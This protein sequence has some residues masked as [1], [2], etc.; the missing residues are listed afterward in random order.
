[1]TER[2][3]ITEPGHVAQILELEANFPCRTCRQDERD[4]CRQHIQRLADWWLT[5]VRER[6]GIETRIIAG[7]T[8]KF[9]TTNANVAFFA[10]PS[11]TTGELPVFCIALSHDAIGDDKHNQLQVPH[12]DLIKRGDRKLAAGIKEHYDRCD[13]R[14]IRHRVLNDSGKPLKMIR[15]RSLS[16]PVIEADVRESLLDLVEGLKTVTRV[17][18]AAA[19]V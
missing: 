12:L 13:M 19:A 10:T 11:D 15:L 5:E 16:I 9:P 1:M 8:E 4:K 7:P 3:I 14:V 17:Q 2:R 18:P 6:F